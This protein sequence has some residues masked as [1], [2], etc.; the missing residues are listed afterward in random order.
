MIV[1]KVLTEPSA[2]VKLID[3]VKFNAEARLGYN[4]AMYSV[5]KLSTIVAPHPS[6]PG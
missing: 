2:D 5:S 3:A 4:R 1:S 6:L